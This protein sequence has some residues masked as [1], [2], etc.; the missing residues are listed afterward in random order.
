[1][2]TVLASRSSPPNRVSRRPD[3]DK[4]N[5][6]DI[7]RFSVKLA[8]KRPGCTTLRRETWK[9][10]DSQL[11]AKL[12]RELGAAS[13]TTILVLLQ[14]WSRASNLPFCFCRS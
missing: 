2:S 9:W 10:G 7:V 1:M 4:H 8:K 12:S 13:V 3:V 6:L 5:I 11:D 14:E